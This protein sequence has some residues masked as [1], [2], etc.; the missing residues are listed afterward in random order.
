MRYI[1]ASASPRRQ[2]LLA[3][4]L[5]DPFEVQVSDVDEE[6]EL[7]DPAQLVQ[8]LAKRKAQA[9]AKGQK[10]AIVFGADTVV[11]L[12]GQIFGKPRDRQQAKAMLEQ[13]SGR[14]HTVYTGV[15]V[16]HAES[17]RLL[18]EADCTQVTFAPM[19]QEEIE[20]Y[21]DTGEYADKAGAY[22][23]QGGAAKHIEG[24][25]GCYFNVMGLPVHS[26]Y[27]LLK[28]ILRGEG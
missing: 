24:I 25:L 13:L 3:L 2:E 12:D 27:R 1:L 20:A 8:E 7:S 26:T 28:R 5:D 23:I 21:L 18:C 14:T 11:A 4:V 15:A 19:Q 9:V 22:G 16:L 6:T 10:D 17:G